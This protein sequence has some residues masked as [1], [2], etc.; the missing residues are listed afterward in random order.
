MLPRM[1]ADLAGTTRF[2][3]K[4]RRAQLFLDTMSVSRSQYDR[5]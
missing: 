4:I 3:F 5:R 2:V 1:H